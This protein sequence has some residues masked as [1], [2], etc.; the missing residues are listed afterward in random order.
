MERR[1]IFGAAAVL[2]ATPLL[3]RSKDANAQSA[4][5]EAI[6]TA[7][8]A[9]YAALSAR[10]LKAMEAV[11]ANK[12]YVVNIGPRSKTVLVGYDAAVSKY[13]AKSF[14]FFSQMDGSMASIAQIYSDGKI[15][16][17]I[18]ME[19]AKLQPRS[20]GDP[21]IFDTFVTNIFE[22]DGAAWQMIS[23]HSQMIP[24]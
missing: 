22:K 17:V 7:N 8:Q 18:G 4:D 6:K 24:K 16:Y 15:G 3:M 21:L 12:P 19:S 13:W 20:G 14:D 10:D 5:V 1:Q 23:H 9:F 11:W 2:A